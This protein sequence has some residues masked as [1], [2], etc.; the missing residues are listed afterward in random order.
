VFPASVFPADLFQMEV[1]MG[2]S[3]VRLLTLTLA[4]SGLAPLITILASSYLQNGVL[5]WLQLPVYLLIALG[6]I[7]LA[8]LFR[9]W[10]RRIEDQGD[11]AAAEQAV[12]LLHE[13]PEKWINPAIVASALLSLFLELAIIR[14]QATVFPFFSFYK[15]LSLL[16][17]FAG[18]GLG[19]ALGRRDRVPLFLTMPLLCCQ[20]L[21]MIGMRYG[22]S[23]EQ[24]HSLYA[25]PFRE[26]LNMGLP[27]VGQY[28]QAFQ[29]YY[30]LSV[31]FLM[32]A[33]AFVPVGQLCGCLMQRREKLTAYG[34]NLLGSLAGVLLMF[35]VS[36]YWTPPAL[37]F[38]IAFA[39]LIAFH[40]RR[41]KVL[42][43]SISAGILA[44]LILEWPVS[45][46]WQRIYSPY[47]L[48]EVGRSEHG[49][50]EIRAAGHYYQKVYDFINSGDRGPADSDVRIARNYYELPYRI[51]Q[52][53]KDV[54]IVGAGSGND[55]AA[56]LRAGAEHVDAI[57]IDPAI[58]M[59]G[60]DG[61]PE[62]PY[63][64]KRV[65]AV[66]TDARS[67]LRTTD[68]KYDLIVF[69]LLDSHSLL[70]QASS[71]RLDSFV[72]TVQA[73]QEA[74]A[75]LKPH[76]M[77]SLT[78][79]VL[80]DQLGR[81]IYL[82]LKDAFDGR[83][84]LCYMIGYDSGIIFLESE[85]PLTL[86]PDLLAK[87][88]F[89]DKTA[90]YANPNIRADVSTD[91]WPFF[92]MPARIYP[93]SYLGMVVLVLALS[94]F[95]ISNFLPERPQIGNFP[96]FLLGA[97]FMLIETKGITE[98]GL[99]FGNSWQVIGVVIAAIMVMAFLANWAVQQLKIERLGLPYA[100]LLAS[101][102]VGWWVAKNGGLPSTWSGRVGTAMLLTSPMFFSGI[103]FSAL[104]KSRGDISGVMS[105]NLFG[106][107]CGGLLEYNSMYFGFRFLY[108]IAAALY[109]LAIGWEFVPFKWKTVAAVPARAV[110]VAAGQ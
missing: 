78:F 36:A 71:V 7:S 12:F 70:S 65:R 33:L 91:D 104:L 92:Y 98:L 89:L 109:L 50:M 10:L 72:Y 47:Q 6:I 93:V 105:A 64:D 15:N 5:P 58:L 102:A 34:L 21:F 59:L 4:G 66:N 46:D 103:V 60:R 51:K 76:G 55:V 9:W 40:V 62:H 81:K 75:R 69:G 17:C 73:M 79:T 108:L 24:F 101:L 41:V 87:K 88:R 14:W 86:P 107:M 56:A 100:L 54:A 74:R 43:L 97:G 8:L 90:T 67:F 3:Y 37:W 52:Q 19:Y 2:R 25:L 30:V 96:F 49:F 26:Q 28:W 77:I 83:A 38:V 99:T 61:H 11:T 16:S 106:A 94:L 57:E 29:S 39:F 22:M 82:M 13:V 80:N 23:Y 1:L 44:L 53:P 32:T 95:L 42:R 48:L 63:A 85:D 31:V 68:Q 18:M 20:F 45:P 35:L 110:G 27:Q 84:P